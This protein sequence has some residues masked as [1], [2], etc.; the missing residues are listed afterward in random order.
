MSKPKHR[1]DETLEEVFEKLDEADVDFL[2]KPACELI[3]IYGKKAYAYYWT[4][5]RWNTYGMKDKHYRSKG[6][7]DF[8]TRFFE[9]IDE[10][11]LEGVLIN[12]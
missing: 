3:W 12:E 6:I 7:D 2:Y 4:T 10:E 1:L 11:E 9:D 5:G 8:L